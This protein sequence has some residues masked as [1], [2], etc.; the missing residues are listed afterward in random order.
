MSHLPARRPL[1]A[2]DLSEPLEHIDSEAPRHPVSWAAV[3]RNRWIILGCMVA[4]VAMAL[5]TTRRKVPMYEGASTL[6]IEPRES[7]LPEAFRRLSPA[8]SWLPTE[9]EELQSRALAAEV[10]KELGLRLVVL[11]PQVGRRDDLLR[12]IRVAD[13]AEGAVYR[14]TRRPDGGVAIL[15][16]SSGDQLAAFAPQTRVEFAGFSF[17][18]AAAALPPQGI[19]FAVQTLADATGQ[20]AGGLWVGQRNRDVNIVQVAYRSPDQELAW[21]VPQALVTRYIAQRQEL[22]TLEL[23][24]TIVYLEKQIATIATELAEA[25]RKLESYRQRNEV[26]APHTEADNQIT[27]L[28]AMQTERG[29]LQDERSS[30]AALLAEVD[31]TAAAHKPGQPSAYRRLLTFPKLL[32][33]EAA[34]G[35]LRS[36]TSLEIQ[37]EELLVRR[38]P[39]DS[40]V[41]AMDQRIHELERELRGIAVTYQQGLTSQIQAIDTRLATFRR[42]L[43]AIPEK[44]LQY[45]RLERQPKILEG[46]Y[47]MLQTRLK[48]AEVT[49][50][51]RDPS[52]RI[53]DAAIPPSGPISPRSMRTVM[54]ALML[55]IGRAHV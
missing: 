5:F 31:A 20:V 50:A 27:R 45:A 29:M 37:R 52:V 19:R 22:Q 24:S 46:V 12:D 2:A 41:R 9:I 15:E 25:E 51:A 32:H 35:L 28:V 36:L 4:A 48:E 3:L 34:T 13:T 33:S 55:E 16:D 30:V 44:E 17:D 53:V 39:Q 6:R 11:E 10:A 23:R 8:V 43:Q 18:V 49:V 21:Q 7:S 40:D 14:L 42:Q 26:I 47:T 1:P 54:A 38:T